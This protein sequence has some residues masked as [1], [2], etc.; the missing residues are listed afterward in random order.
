MGVAADQPH[1]R[2]PAVRGTGVVGSSFA[3]GAVA[4]VAFGAFTALFRDHTARPARGA[5]DPF[6]CAAAR[7]WRAT[8]E[9]AA[10]LRVVGVHVDAP[11]HPT[12]ET[13][14]RATRDDARLKAAALG[15]HALDRC[16]A[17][18]AWAVEAAGPPP[19]TDQLLH[20]VRRIR[21]G[22]TP[23]D[24]GAKRSDD[25]CA[26]LRTSTLSEHQAQVVAVMALREIGA[27]AYGLESAEHPHSLV[28]TYVD[29]PGWIALD[30]MDPERGYTSGGAAFVAKVP[31]VG[32][33]S[34]ARDGFWYPAAIAYRA[35]QGDPA[36]LSW[37]TWNE[38]EQA[39]THDSTVTFDRPL[40]EV[41]R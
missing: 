29:G 35:W 36:P 37:T 2:V 21:A 30:V 3:L 31:L 23:R 22:V 12:F 10:D 25:V 41:C 24:A 20:I 9:A 8:H 6:I 11:P 14:P 26:A 39:Q 7:G 19:Y 4:I 27:P 40:A 34:G 16:K 33:F 18:P 17:F 38:V 1:G 32:A 15:D 13:L 5:A 28:A